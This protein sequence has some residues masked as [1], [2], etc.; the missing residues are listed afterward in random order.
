MGKYNKDEFFMEI[1]H[2]VKLQSHCV[3][4]QVGAVIVKDGRIISIG[5]NG[6]PVG[7]LNCDDIFDSTKFDP[8]KHHEFSMNNEIHAEINAIIYAAK[9]STNLDNSTIYVT[10]SPCHDCAKFIV[11]SGIK[12]VIYDKLYEREGEKPLTFMK[13][14]GIIVEQYTPSFN[15]IRILNEQYIND[16]LKNR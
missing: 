2:L 14:A 16:M 5:Y 13:K 4:E 10:M 8:D 12:K 9:N 3:K 11:A 15:L 1:T 6:T 7:V